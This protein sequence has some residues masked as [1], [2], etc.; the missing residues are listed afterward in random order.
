MGGSTLNDFMHSS[1]I[2]SNLEASSSLREQQ[3]ND[4]T[5]YNPFLN[6]QSSFSTI[7]PTYN[8]SEFQLDPISLLPPELPPRPAAY[9]S[10]AAT[11]SPT[12]SSNNKVRLIY[13]KS[14]FYLKTTSINSIHGFFAIVSK[15]MENVN[16]LIAWIPEYLIEPHDITKFIELDGV[17][18]VDQGF[19]TIDLNFG[20]EETM[21]IGI[22]NIHSLYICPPLSTTQGSIIITSRTGDILKPLWYSALNDSTLYHNCYLDKASWPGYDIIDILDAFTP[23]KR[24][25]EHLYL[26]GESISDN[27]TNK[28]NINSVKEQEFSAEEACGSSMDPITK[29]LQEARWNL[30]ERFSR[31]TQ[32][33]RNTAAQVLEHPITRP[34]LPLMPPSVQ[35]LSRNG[36]VQNTINEYNMASYYL[37]R[38]SITT[39]ASRYYQA[40]DLDGLLVGMPELYGPAPIHTRRSPLL[41]EEWVQLFDNEG[42]LAVSVEYVRKLIFR[43]GIHS[44]IRIEAWKFLLGIYPWDSNFN[45]R[46]ALR[47]SRLDA[48]YN[49]KARWFD[50]P[51]VCSTKEFQDE[52]HRIDKDVHRTD[53]TQA[54]FEAEDLPNPDPAMAVGTNPNLETMKDILVT[55][56]FHN[57]ELGGYVQG[58]SDLLAPLF[59][60]MGNEAMAFWTFSALMDRVQ[61]NFFIDQ[62]GM[63]RQLKTLNALIQFMDPNLY[64]RLEE[65]E[66]SNLF[67][68]FRWL[69]VC[70]KREFEWEDVIRLWEVLW[71]D[72]LTDKMILFIALA[73]IDM[74]RKQMME[75]LNQFDEI[76]KYINDLT[77]NIPLEPV[78][79]RAEVL[80]YLFERKVRAIQH[81]KRL[82]QEQLQSRA[83]WNSNERQK[84]LEHIDKLNICDNLLALLPKIPSSTL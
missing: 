62:S 19:P 69:L 7:Y 4:R 66:S 22:K 30:L 50:H 43:G 57:T 41:P 40:D 83:V 2:E 8:P 52:K 68:C 10:I 56:N 67:F 73:I 1:I 16:I 71:T 76:I 15:S 63:H 78:L 29:V 34:L 27:N 46:E 77:G 3:L 53:R 79:E 75:E 36:N 33:S 70:F 44:D 24:D 51:E 6:H 26:V 84:I 60:V 74:H 20:E 17:L 49:I 80:F 55:Y 59:V 37:A 25:A 48:Y 81:K 58:M 9:R 42:R 18:A 72:Y 35:A 32:Y 11:T 54:A 12:A 61:S 64:R 82:L 5:L 14:G 13:T 28:T 21:T 65:T 45:E 31:I 39:S 38:W 23:L 47:R